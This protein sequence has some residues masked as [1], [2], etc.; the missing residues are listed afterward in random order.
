MATELPTLR[1]LSRE[2]DYDPNSMPVDKA[3]ELICRFLE[4]VI[5][6][7]QVHIRATLGRILARDVISPLDVPAHDNSAMDGFAVRHSDLNDRAETT[8]QVL[9]S[10]F[11][12]KPYVGPIEVGQCVRIMTGGVVPPGMDTI[13]MQEHVRT[14]DGKVVIGPGHRKNQNLRRAGEDLARGGVALRRGKLITPENSG[15]L[16]FPPEMNSYRSVARLEKGRYTTAIVT[17]STECCSVWVWT[18]SIWVSY[19]TTPL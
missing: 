9:G 16:F 3:R 7:E 6:I 8:L 14:T 1:D 11:A 12:G 15:L 2:D 17:P 18:P 10:S 5:G 19:E 13:V 4:P